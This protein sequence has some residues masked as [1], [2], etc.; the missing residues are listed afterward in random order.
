MFLPETIYEEEVCKDAPLEEDL[1]MAAMDTLYMYMGKGI[2]PQGYGDPLYFVRKLKMAMDR[3]KDEY[4]S[5]SLFSKMVTQGGAILASIKNKK[6]KIKAIYA[7]LTSYAKKKSL[8]G[9][10]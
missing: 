7:L 3:K 8:Q 9:F 4:L 10:A 6:Q 5:L 2:I 1:P